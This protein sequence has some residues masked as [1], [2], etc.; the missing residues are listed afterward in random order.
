MVIGHWNLNTE[1]LLEAAEMLRLLLT[2]RGFVS[3]IKIKTV[4]LT[5]AGSFQ[6][7]FG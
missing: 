6:P 5:S 3:N 7:L 2:Q 4:L 1:I